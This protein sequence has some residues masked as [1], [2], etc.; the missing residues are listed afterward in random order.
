M[1]KGNINSMLTADPEYCVHVNV[2]T[3]VNDCCEQAKMT[4]A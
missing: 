1:K 2:V 3:E 4:Q